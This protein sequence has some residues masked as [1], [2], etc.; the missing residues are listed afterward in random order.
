MIVTLIQNQQLQIQYHVVQRVRVINLAREHTPLQDQRI[1][2][3]EVM[4][5]PLQT[6]RVTDNSNQEQRVLVVTEGYTVLSQAHVQVVIHT[7]TIRELHLLV[8]EDSLNQATTPRV[9]VYT[10]IILPFLMI[11]AKMQGVIYHLIITM[12]DTVLN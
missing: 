12:M 1:A 11:C 8:Q 10:T 4:V 9:L 7:P 6:D 3:E 2:L 5:A